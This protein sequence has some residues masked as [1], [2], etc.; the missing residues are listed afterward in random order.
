MVLAI[1]F[2]R[3][4]K[5]FMNTQEYPKITEKHT[6]KIKLASKVDTNISRKLPHPGLGGR[7]REA[8]LNEYQEPKDKLTLSLT[9]TAKLNLKEQLSKKYKLPLTDIFE[10]LARSPECLEMVAE[11]LKLEERSQKIKRLRQDAKK[12]H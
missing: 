1:T 8:I 4:N 3:I 12:H 2:I 5:V 6:E 9:A 10:Q 7:K 11:Q